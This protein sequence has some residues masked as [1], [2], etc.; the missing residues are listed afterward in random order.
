VIGR[1]LKVLQVEK[2][3]EYFEIFHR[4][5]DLGK[6]YFYNCKTEISQWEKPKGWPADE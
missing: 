2:G 3:F 1:N 6:T 4:D 5:F